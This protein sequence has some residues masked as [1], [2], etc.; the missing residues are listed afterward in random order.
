MPTTVSSDAWWSRTR[1][2]KHKRDLAH[3]VWEIRD[4]VPESFLERSNPLKD[5]PDLRDKSMDFVICDIT[6]CNLAQVKCKLAEIWLELYGVKTI[7]GLRKK[8]IQGYV[9]EGE[10]EEEFDD[11]DNKKPRTQEYVPFSHRPGTFL[12]TFMLMMQLCHKPF[13]SE[14]TDQPPIVRR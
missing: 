9:E 14:T 11:E 13:P 4:S 6:S 10:V 5:R 3:Q 8:I 12:E 7:G 2:A 1:R